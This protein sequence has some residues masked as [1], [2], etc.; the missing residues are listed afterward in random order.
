[1]T[2]QTAR[3][4]PEP[5]AKRLRAA[6]IWAAGWLALLSSGGVGAAET[7]DSGA[8]QL[9][10]LTKTALETADH[11][12]ALLAE[13]EKAVQER[14]TESRDAFQACERDEACRA[15]ERLRDL[16]TAF[17]QAHEQQRRLSA[18]REQA[19]QSRT[20]LETRLK[21]LAQQVGDV[22]CPVAKGQ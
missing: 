12:V 4:A 21:A 10:G 14:V 19:E 1:M 22:D 16:E 6:A 11:G 15:S 7:E 2:R 5:S 17:A 20:E 3:R 13:L 9:I 18:S 8:C